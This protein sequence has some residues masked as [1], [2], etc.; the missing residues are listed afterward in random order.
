M[1][2]WFQD[3]AQGWAVGAFG[4]LVTTENGGQHWVNQEKVL[5]NPDEFHLN[6]ITGDGKGRVFIAGEGGVM[7]RSLDGG[8]S[9]EALE[10]FYEGSWFGV[11]YSA[12]MTLCS[13]SGCAATCTALRLR[14]DL[15]AGIQ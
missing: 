5:D 6:A 12:P 10:P 15:D 4:T 9:W 13:C 11:V 7:F 2:V 14:H 1:D 3:A 8:L